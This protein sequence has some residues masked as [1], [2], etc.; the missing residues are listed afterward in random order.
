MMTT[1]PFTTQDH[2]ITRHHTGGGKA[3]T[4]VER[5]DIVVDDEVV[6]TITWVAALLRRMEREGWAKQDY[7]ER[8]AARYTGGRA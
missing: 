8:I 2:T 3:P 5:T 1:P 7:I 6:F 4:V